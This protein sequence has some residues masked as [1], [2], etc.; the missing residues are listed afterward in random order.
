MKTYK[1]LFI[2]IFLMHMLTLV[3]ATVF[4]GE[5]NGIVMWISTVLFLIAIIYF[6]TEHRANKQVTR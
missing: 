4:N 3:N 5:L 6:S 2:I 1:V